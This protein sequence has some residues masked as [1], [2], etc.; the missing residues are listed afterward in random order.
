MGR[1]VKFLT[2]LG[3][4]GKM[5]NI[6]SKLRTVTRLRDI[7]NPAYKNDIAY[8]QGCIDTLEWLLN[9]KRVENETN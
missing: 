6:E 8:Y 5:K 7:Q 1:I 9:N 2:I 4:K 3:K